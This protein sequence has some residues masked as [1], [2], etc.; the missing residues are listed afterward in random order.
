[1]KK[2]KYYIIFMLVFAF[3]IV[4]N[5]VIHVY[6]T[7]Q[8][9]NRIHKITVGDEQ[10]DYTFT[11]TPQNGSDVSWTR[12]AHIGDK[13]IDL[14]AC[15]FEGVFKNQSEI[16]VSDWK[17]RLDITEDCYVNAAWCGLVEIHQ[18]VS[19]G[20][21]VQILDLRNFDKSEVILSYYEDGD[22]FLFPLKAGDYLVYYPNEEAKELSF[23]ATAN[24]PG[25]VSIG[26]IIYWDSSEDFS[27]P[28][29]AV[30]YQTRKGYLQ[31]REAVIFAITSF[32]WIL[33]LVAGIAVN[34]SY[35]LMCKQSEIENSKRDI[36][37]QTSERMLDELIQALASSIDA[38]DAYTHGHSER[39]AQYALKLAQ[40]LNL[41][42]TECKKVF[43][44]GLVH[45]VGKIA[46]SENIINKTGRLT[47]EEFE[48]IKSHP[49]RGE[50]ILTKI[51]DM[52]YL[53][54]GAKYHHERYDG[55]GY[56]SNAMGEEIPLL[57]RIIAVADSYDAMTSQRSYRNTLDQKIVK[58][59]IWKGIGTQFDPLVA[60]HMI[61]MIDADV[62]YDMREKI[63]EK[64]EIINE[65]KSNEFWAD[66]NP[67][68]IK[69]EEKL[70]SDAS[71][72]YFAEFIC[73]VDNW[74]NPKKLSLIGQEEKQ[75]RFTSKTDE[76]A[77]YIWN[78]PTVIIYTSA[79]GEPVGQDYKE[80]AV[81]MCA[82]YS[83][84]TGITCS[85]ENSLYR[86]EAFVDWNN[87]LSKNKEGLEYT[88][89]AKRENNIITLKVENDL[90]LV[91]GRVVLPEDFEGN[92]YICVTGENTR[93]D[94]YFL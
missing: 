35:A 45:D 93:I 47:D 37:R 17:L 43:Y 9:N 7:N 6:R 41:S 83:W 87:W 22:I 65:I 14:N 21:K 58:Q 67:K 2:R 11:F 76:G 82:G 15:S 24:G 74:C 56:P 72:K 69:S 36:E 73:T 70:M 23:A 39:V 71:I 91:S 62:D 75:V 29:Y 34:I 8:F 90:I 42:S 61:S 5:F 78:V 16:E 38:K 57:A 1:M 52:P 19:S 66:Y 80:L 79:D 54:L 84:K 48:V 26:V 20:E 60:K 51:E 32:I 33:M 27:K 3:F 30:E 85:E 18:F 81:F 55:K 53:A 86:K 88:I 89:T 68:S 77:E 28:D 59:E 4:L 25:Q 50:K 94:N 46:I 44:A 92:T 10:S 12:T 49:A 63:D 13:T 64:Y 40:K 31:G